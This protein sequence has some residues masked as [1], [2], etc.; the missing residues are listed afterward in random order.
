MINVVKMYGTVDLELFDANGNIKQKVTHHNI[1]SLNALYA[2]CYNQDSS[3]RMSGCVGLY[4]STWAGPIVNN[5]NISAYSSVHSCLSAA[6][7]SI[8]VTSMNI[9]Q[10]VDPPYM[11]MVW[12]FPAGSGTGLIKSLCTG[13]DP[14][15]AGYWQQ[16]NSYHGYVGTMVSLLELEWINK[17][18]TD[19]LTVTWRIYIGGDPY[20]T[21]ML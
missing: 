3:Y 20:K 14:G 11:Q 12:S 7:A 8:G 10:T 21:N 5:D 15:Q 6:Y 13:R 4:V 16:P 18:I 17:T 19:A 1:I 2:V 9:Y